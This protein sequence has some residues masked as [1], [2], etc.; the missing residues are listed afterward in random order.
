MGSISLRDYIGG[1]RKS[2]R[3]LFRKESSGDEPGGK[4]IKVR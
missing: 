2:L 1:K 4:G 3:K